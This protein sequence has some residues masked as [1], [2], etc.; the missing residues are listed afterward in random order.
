VIWIALTRLPESR[1][2]GR[3]EPLDWRGA[4]LATLGLGA[5]VFGLVRAGS[6]AF[7]DPVTASA[8]AGGV[9]LLGSFLF[10][11]GRLGRDPG[12]EG[13]AMMPLR[14]FTAPTFAGVNLLTLFLYAGLSMA[15][16]V[17]PFTLIDRHGYSVTAAAGAMLPFVIVMFT[18]SRWAGQ[19]R[20]RYGA[21]LPLVVGPLIAAAGF[22][23]MARVAAD[24]RYVAAV[25]PAILVMSAGIAVTVAP[26]TTTVM[27]AVD[28]DHAGV[29]SGINNAIARLASLLAVA[30]AGIV[31]AGA[32]A[33]ALDR[34]AVV[35]AILAVM[36][37]ITAAV[38]VE[39]GPP[40]VAGASSS[41]SFA[42]QGVDRIRS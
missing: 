10:V 20:D 4:I 41:A 19:L 15:T 35:A 21:R 33:D 18:L 5:F 39:R 24:G 13:A 26:L 32:F 23:L 7:G 38:L 2:P 11:E 37:A 42:P 30:L 16:F 6:H 36:G 29:A 34:A 40:R 27:A 28:D 25:L 22:G 12:S 14:L 31:S 1:G 3:V 17:L 9:V 8:L